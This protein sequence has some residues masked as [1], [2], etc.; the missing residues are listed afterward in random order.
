M[1]S[2]TKSFIDFIKQKKILNS[3]FSLLG[4]LADRAIYF[5]CVNFFLFIFYLNGAKLF[6]DLLD[7]FSQFV[8][9]MVGICVN[10]IDPDLFFLFLKESCH[11]N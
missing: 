2:W 5:A 4:K 6:Q 11:G 10:V 1:C 7:R 3:L 8:H 9:Q